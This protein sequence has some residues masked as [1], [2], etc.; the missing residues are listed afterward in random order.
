M[1]NLVFDD[2]RHAC[3][4]AYTYVR[5][6]EEEKDINVTMTPEKEILGMMFIWENFNL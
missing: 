5:G 4:R 6:R 3:L 1:H 2:S